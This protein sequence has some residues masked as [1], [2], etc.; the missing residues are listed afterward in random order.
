M[1]SFANWCEDFAILLVC[2]ASCRSERQDMGLGRAGQRIAFHSGRCTVDAANGI[3]FTVFA[4]DDRLILGTDIAALDA[5]RSIE[6]DRDEHAGSRHLLRVEGTRSTD[7]RA[8]IDIDGSHELMT[9]ARHNRVVG[10]YSFVLLATV[11]P[12]P[13]R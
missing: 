10:P 5:E 8:D 3:G 6:L 13:N 9:H 7:Q 4:L 2:P 12:L 11:L 1:I